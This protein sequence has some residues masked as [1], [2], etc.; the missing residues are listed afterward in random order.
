MRP[1]PWLPARP[2]ESQPSRET[3]LAASPR[4]QQDRTGR[5]GAGGRRENPLRASVDGTCSAPKMEE[6]LLG[7]KQCGPAGSAPAQIYRDPNN[8]TSV[9]P[10]AKPTSSDGRLGPTCDYGTDT[11]GNHCCQP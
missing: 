9:S 10:K 8:R 11:A 3:H 4:L 2:S 6:S 5:Y 1:A 7:P